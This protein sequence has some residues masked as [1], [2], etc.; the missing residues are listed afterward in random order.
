MHLQ[1][2][3]ILQEGMTIYMLISMATIQ[4]T[5]LHPL[6]SIV[7]GDD[8]IEGMASCNV[9]GTCFCNGFAMWL[10]CVLQW[11]FAMWLECVLQWVFA[12]WLECVFAMGLQCVLVTY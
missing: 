2:N 6:L 12:M 3:G 8:Q 1:N 7:E 4:H 9:V 10:E 5:S 11:V